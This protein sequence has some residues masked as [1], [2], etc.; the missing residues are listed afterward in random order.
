M[1]NLTYTQITD[2]CQSDSTKD[3]YANGRKLFKKWL[4]ENH[5]SQLDNSVIGI[6]LP[7]DIK[8]ILQYLTFK[9]LKSNGMYN[10]YSTVSSARNIILDLHG[11]SNVIL[12]PE[13]KLETKTFYSTHYI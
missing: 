12:S 13:V 6:K 10:S 9:T 11:K 2:K 4:V 8:I 7:I 1:N 5:P 3:V